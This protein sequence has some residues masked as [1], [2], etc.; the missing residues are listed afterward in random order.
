[1][2]NGDWVRS[3]NNEDL[4]Q[5]IVKMMT[6]VEGRKIDREN[7]CLNLVAMLYKERKE[8]GDLNGK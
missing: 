8:E 7:A 6:V 4:A 3:M 5:F 2:T 1:M